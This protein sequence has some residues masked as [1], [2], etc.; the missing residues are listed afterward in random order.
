MNEGHIRGSKASDA[1][2]EMMQHQSLQP[3]NFR[4]SVIYE[5][6]S[7]GHVA[8]RTA[9]PLAD[10][11]DLRRSCN[12]Y[13]RS[14]LQGSTLELV[15]RTRDI[16]SN[17]FDRKGRYGLYKHKFKDCVVHNEGKSESVYFCTL[18]N[19]EQPLGETLKE[20]IHRTASSIQ[21]NWKPFP[22]EL[23]DTAASIYSDIARN[24]FLMRGMLVHEKHPEI[25][26]DMISSL[27]D[28][29]A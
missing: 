25:Y 20:I 13:H 19:Y 27:R 18:N 4:N 12:S 21:K 28:P 6:D 23:S 10:F 5:P 3:D 11:R 26:M 1:I 24:V 15:L 8:V 9:I 17:R 7:I 22:A 14:T 29:F 16:I 2:E